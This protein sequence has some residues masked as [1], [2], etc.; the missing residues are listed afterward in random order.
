MKKAITGIII[1][2]I[3]VGISPWFFG[4]GITVQFDITEN[5]VNQINSTHNKST[6]S[7]TNVGALIVDV[8]MR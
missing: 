4:P 3:I 7:I 5:N 6:Y 1:S 8:R 2:A